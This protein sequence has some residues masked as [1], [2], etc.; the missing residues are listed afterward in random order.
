MFRLRGSLHSGS[1]SLFEMFEGGGDFFNAIKR[2]G[3]MSPSISST[4][5]KEVVLQADTKYD[6]GECSIFRQS[7]NPLSGFSMTEQV[8][9]CAVWP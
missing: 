5:L 1:N 6:D 4:V 8:R 9:L 7:S 2:R 3:I